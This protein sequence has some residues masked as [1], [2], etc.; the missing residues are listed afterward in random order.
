MHGLLEL[1]QDEKGSIWKHE[2]GAGEM[3][4]CLRALD[5]D[6]VHP[7]RECMDHSAGFRTAAAFTARPMT[8]G[9]L[10]RL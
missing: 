4:L 6:A 9:S 10:P 2:L 5:G 8:L 1:E 7:E 3:R